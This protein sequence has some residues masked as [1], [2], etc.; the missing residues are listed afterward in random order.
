[1]R[2][3]KQS[4]THQR[5]R[6]DYSVISELIHSLAILVAYIM[7]TNVELPKKVEGG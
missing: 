5:P 2:A 3:Y 6:H 1:M 7:F 4:H